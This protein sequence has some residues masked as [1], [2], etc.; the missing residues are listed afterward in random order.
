MPVERVSKGNHMFTGPWTDSKQGTLYPGA[1]VQR[2]KEKLYE[3]KAAE[4]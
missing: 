2:W 4:D 1:G 3:E